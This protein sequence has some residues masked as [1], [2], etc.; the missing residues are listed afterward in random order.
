MMVQARVV[1]FF[2]K[3]C[4]VKSSERIVVSINCQGENCATVLLYVLYELRE[5]LFGAQ[6][7]Q[8]FGSACFIS[9]GTPVNLEKFF[10]NPSARTPAALS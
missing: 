9:S 7:D 5:M 10:R 8:P 1:R 3:K 6:E 4:K 2:M